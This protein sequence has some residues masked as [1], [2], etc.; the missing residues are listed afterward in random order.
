MKGGRIFASP[1]HTSVVVEAA[2]SEPR[3]ETLVRRGHDVRRLDGLGRLNVIYCASGL[4]V[5]SL[6]YAK[7]SPETD[8]RG[9][10]FGMTFLLQ[11]E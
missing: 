1:A 6:R 4:P 7:C 5:D 10:G 9:D 2:E 11:G 3:V 8:N